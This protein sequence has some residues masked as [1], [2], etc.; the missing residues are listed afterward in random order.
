MV[1]IRS[2]SG[3]TTL[4]THS[5]AIEVLDNEGRLALVVTQTAGGSVRILTKGDPEFN[6]YANICK[7]KA[8][9]VFVH[10]PVKEKIAR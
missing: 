7:L 6:A 4:V 5:H 8:S 1:Q 2:K 9:S 10:E 3:A